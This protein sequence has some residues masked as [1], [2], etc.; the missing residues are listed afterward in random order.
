MP[1]H[2]TNPGLEALAEIL[3]TSPA[4]ITAETLLVNHP[5]W[6]STARVMFVAM[7]D[8]TFG[9]QVR[10]ADVAAA[11]TVGDLLRLLD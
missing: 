2:P 1:N 3:M 11:K 5:G 4:E 10:G 7:V 6:D 9:R 8:H